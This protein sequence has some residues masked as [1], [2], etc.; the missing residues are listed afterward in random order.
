[1]TNQPAPDFARAAEVAGVSMA[2]PLAHNGG[3]IDKAEVIRRAERSMLR[4]LPDFSCCKNSAKE[5]AI[6]GGGPSI[7]DHVG[8]I[9]ALKRR[10]VNIVSVN[11]SHD[12]L[13]ENGIVP[14]GHVMLDPKEWVSEYVKRPRRDVRYFVASQCHDATFDALKGYPV[15]LWHA[16][17]DFPDGANEPT[18]TLYAKYSHRSWI[19]VPGPTTVGLRTAS[20]GHILGADTFHLIGLDSSRRAGKMHGYEKPE[21]KDATSGKTKLK[22]RGQ[23]YKFDNNSHMARQHRDFDEIIH[24][25]KEHVEGGRLRKEFNFVVHGSGLIPFHAAMLGLHAD[26]KCNEDPTLVGG[27][28]TEAEGIAA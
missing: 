21:A 28:L 9:R 15:F 4:G 25:F 10:G 19:V 12:W 16:G 22:Y 20:L 8:T 7:N 2:D 18:K 13:L 5:W 27:Y 14:W 24:K 6:I 26:P 1:M 17:Q 23:T 3:R 11:K